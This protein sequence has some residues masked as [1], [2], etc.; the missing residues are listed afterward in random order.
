[1]ESGTV[2]R[3]YFRGNVRTSNGTV[4]H[5]KDGGLLAHTPFSEHPHQGGDS[6]GDLGGE[7]GVASVLVG[8]IGR[9]GV[10]SEPVKK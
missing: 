6:G 5:A 9:A 3:H 10:E 4:D 1:M 8:A 2:V 7:K